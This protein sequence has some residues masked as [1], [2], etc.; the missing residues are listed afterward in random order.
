APLFYY[1]MTDPGATPDVSTMLQ[2]SASLASGDMK[3][4][5]WTATVP[6]PVAAAADGTTATIYYVFVADDHDSTNNCDHSSQSPVYSMTVTAGGSS[7]AGL[8]APCSADAQ[9]GDGNECVYV[10]TLGDSYCLASCAAGCAA[11]Y[12]CS[13]DAIWSVDGAM[14]NQCVPQS[15]SCAMPTGA[16][17]DDDWERND[18]RADALANAALAPDLYELVSCPS[19]TSTS[20]AND[21]WFRVELA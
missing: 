9:C 8:C 2:A 12:S 17:E 13:A 18:S 14:A 1:S 3:D 10:G 15:G 21:D 16:C 5:M 4:G 20:V 19:T 11:G 7:T 6:S